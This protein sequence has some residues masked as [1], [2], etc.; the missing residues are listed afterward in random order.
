[1][2]FLM[3]PGV[4]KMPFSRRIRSPGVNRLESSLVFSP[5]DR[6]MVNSR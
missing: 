6:S 2:R 4:E 1:M 5:R 3:V